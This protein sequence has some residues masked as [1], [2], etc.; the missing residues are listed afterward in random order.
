MKG[1]TSS[2]Q[3]QLN[4]K[5]ASSHNHSAA[6]ITS[7]TLPIARGGTGA[8]DTATA[9]SNLG[10][11]FT[12]LYYNY[13]QGWVI[14][15]SDYMVW[16]YS[17][18]VAIGSGPWDTKACPYVL[19]EKYRIGKVFDHITVPLVTNNGDSWTGALVVKSDG[20]IIVKNLGS[21]GSTDVRYGFLCYPVGIL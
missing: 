5:A 7:G 20:Q 18:G 9:R 8:T 21:S 6:N 17:Y 14:Y 19:P 4:G 15:A 10:F 3:T 2:I 11:G 12:Q 16:I 1:V 13:N